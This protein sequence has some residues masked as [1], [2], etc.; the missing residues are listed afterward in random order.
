ME[1]LRQS[2]ECNRYTVPLLQ[3]EVQERE[4]CK[5]DNRDP[6]RDSGSAGRQKG[7]DK[8]PSNE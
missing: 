8:G 1:D 6:E 2:S 7:T 4:E 3:Q 5:E